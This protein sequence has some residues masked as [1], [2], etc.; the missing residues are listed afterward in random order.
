MTFQKK[1]VAQKK[2]LRSIG[3]CCEDYARVFLPFDTACDIF[4]NLNNTTRGVAQSGSASGLGPEGR[5]FKSSRPDHLLKY[6]LC[7]ISMTQKK[8]GLQGPCFFV[9]HSCSLITAQLLN[10]EIIIVSAGT[11][12]G[13]RSRAR[14]IETCNRQAPGPLPA[15]SYRHTHL[16]VGISAHSNPCPRRIAYL[17][18][19]RPVR[20]QTCAGGVIITEGP[21]HIIILVKHKGSCLMRSAIPATDLLPETGHPVITGGASEIATRK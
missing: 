1:L 15:A 7:H 13:R 16:P 20:A 10:L 14:Q 19:A 5:R 4:C 6:F 2:H 11:Y 17:A 8:Q 18:I 12:T 21:Q 9:T 3:I